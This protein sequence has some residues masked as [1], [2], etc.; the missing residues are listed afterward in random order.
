MDHMAITRSGWPAK[1]RETCLRKAPPATTVDRSNLGQGCARRQPGIEHEKSSKRNIELEDE[2][3]NRRT[4]AGAQTNENEER[5]GKNCRSYRRKAR[6]DAGNR[7]S[8]KELRNSRLH[9]RQQEGARAA[10]HQKFLL[11]RSL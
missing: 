7:T 8:A 11:G 2:E 5:S 4:D 1:K 6:K 9:R 10:P 3:R